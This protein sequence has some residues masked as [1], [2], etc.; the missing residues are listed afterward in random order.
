MLRYLPMQLKIF[1][2]FYEITSELWKSFMKYS[3]ELHFFCHWS[4]FN[5]KQAKHTT[6]N[7]HTATVDGILDKFNHPVRLSLERWCCVLLTKIRYF[8]I[9]RD[10]IIIKVCLSP[11]QWNWQCQENFF[12]EAYKW[13][14]VYLLIVLE[15]DLFPFFISKHRLLSC[16][17][18]SYYFEWWN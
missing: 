12:V 15:F 1:S 14:S 7:T 16:F 13:K 11:P 9:Y 4:I 17:C 8:V 3:L 6:L 18:L 2:G 10:K 5:I